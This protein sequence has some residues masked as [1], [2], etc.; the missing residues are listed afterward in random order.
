MKFIILLY[1]GLIILLNIIPLDGASLN[2]TKL[3][4]FRLDYLLHTAL[5]LPWMFFVY[6]RPDPGWKLRIRPVKPLP[7]LS[8]MTL[9]LLLAA[10]SEGIQYWLD[11]RGFN[12]MDALFNALGVV[13]GAVFLVL[14]SAFRVGRIED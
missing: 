2:T 7:F 6:L 14:G 1:V 4:P 11:Y 3:G 13:V 8:W 12:P 9:G 5:F 10:G